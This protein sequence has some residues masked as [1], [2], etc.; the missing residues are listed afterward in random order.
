MADIRQDDP[1][2]RVIAV[3]IPFSSP[4]E[5][6][7]DQFLRKAKEIVIINENISTGDTLGEN[8]IYIVWFAKTL[9]N[10]KALLSTSRPDG[11]YYE[12][13]YNGAVGEAYL[14][15]YSKIQNRVFKDEDLT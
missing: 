3:G 2:R 8:E 11:L 15:V 12:V 9:S 1:S 13:T 4:D 10:W 7:A 5:L 14:D 6:D